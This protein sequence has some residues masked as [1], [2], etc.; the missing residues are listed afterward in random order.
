MSH[1]NNCH[2]KSV[3]IGYKEMFNIIA[4]RILHFC[5]VK[6]TLNMRLRLV[7]TIKLISELPL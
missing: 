7:L 4:F 1:Q 3:I 2:L 6:N 5:N